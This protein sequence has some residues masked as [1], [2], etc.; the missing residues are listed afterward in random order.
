MSLLIWLSD[1]QA[2]AYMAL[3][4]SL[5]CLGFGEVKGR[6]VRR[7]PVR[8]L[9]LSGRFCRML[10]LPCRACVR[11]LRAVRVRA[12]SLAAPCMNVSKAAGTGRSPRA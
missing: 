3:A 6:F 9:G 12:W 10:R 8:G 11:L 2:D 5:P 7:A 4:F 1:V